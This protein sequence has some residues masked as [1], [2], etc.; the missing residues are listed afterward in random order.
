MKTL[1]AACLLIATTTAQADSLEE[2]KFWK[3]N[4][5]YIDEGLKKADKACG[6]TFKFDWENAPTLRA[7]VEKTKH[8]PSG[9]CQSIISVVASICREGEDEKAT[10]KAKIT[11]FTCG[12]AKERTLDFKGSTLRYQGNNTQSNFD[13]WAKPW[14]LKHL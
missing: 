4:R 2:R 9:V 1:I 6:T 3:R 14:L 7:E 5:D 13:E 10:V 8:S 11:G 12:Y